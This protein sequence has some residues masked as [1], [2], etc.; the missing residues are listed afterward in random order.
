MQVTLSPDVLNKLEGIDER[1]MDF[2][3]K[4]HSSVATCLKDLTD[5]FSKQ[6]K[7]S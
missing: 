1:M 3:R 6:L 2:K 7:E 4:L 5:K